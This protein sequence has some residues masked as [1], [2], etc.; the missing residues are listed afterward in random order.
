VEFGPEGRGRARFA[1]NEKALYI[2]VE[3]R[4]SQHVQTRPESEIFAEDSMQIGFDPLA[5]AL[6]GESYG[7]DDYEYGFALTKNG[8]IAWRYEGPGWKQSG[9][10]DN[11][12]VAIRLD[13]SIGVT[14]YEV[15]IPWAELDPAEPVAGKIFRAA[16]LVNDVGPGTE[17]RIF[18]WGGGIAGK[19][20]P[21][22][23]RAV[24]LMR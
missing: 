2:G 14:V 11:V 21:E 1:W 18:E 23:F 19:K 17:R 12:K 9:R 6:P 5:N 13:D 20:Q 15:A 24:M 4:D 3:V 7:P 10:I 8:P 22:L 16:V